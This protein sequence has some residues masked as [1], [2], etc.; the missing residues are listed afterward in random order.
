M[1]PQHIAAQLWTVRSL[2]GDA[3]GL[4]SASRAIRR[5]GYRAVQLAG[6][7]QI[8]PQD[9]RRVLDDAGMKAC[10]AH[11]DADEILERPGRVA[12]KLHIY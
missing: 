12:E 2:L 9:V 11:E 10:S 3:S 8:S 1:Q 7:G 5:I 6:L 4:A